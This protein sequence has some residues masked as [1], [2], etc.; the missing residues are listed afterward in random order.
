MKMA[1]LLV[2][3]MSTILLISSRVIYFLLCLSN[4]ARDGLLV[5]ST[6]FNDL[7]VKHSNVND[8][9]QMKYIG[10]KYIDGKVNIKT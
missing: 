2:P 7:W 5:L 8:K 1:I 10:V 4:E 6:I 9:M 3:S